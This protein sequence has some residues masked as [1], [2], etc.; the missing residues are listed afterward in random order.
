VSPAESILEAQT[1]ALLRRLAR[2]QETRVR[3]LRTEAEDQARDILRRSRSEAHARVRQAITEARR[4]VE[5]GL[6]LRRAA[7]DTQSRRARQALLRQILERAWERLPLALA[8]RWHDSAA[9]EQWC[10]AACRQAMRTLRETRQLR[11]E[12]DVAAAG[13]LA[14]L[15]AGELRTLGA[16]AVQVDPVPALGPGL[17]IRGGDACLDATLPGLLASRGRVASAL[18]AEFDVLWSGTAA[19]TAS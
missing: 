6:A 1:A 2:E 9:R 3:R 11:V 13:T 14:D 17:R 19:E 8:E 4:E 18:L 7:L 5:N 10:L 15:V 12:V 16:G